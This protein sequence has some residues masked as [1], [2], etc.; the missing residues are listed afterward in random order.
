MV[1]VV[2]DGKYES[3]SKND[4]NGGAHNNSVPKR[5]QVV[6]CLAANGVEIYS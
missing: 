1:A 4:V 5:H 6:V 3:G 2:D